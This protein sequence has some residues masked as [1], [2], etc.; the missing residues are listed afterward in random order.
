MTGASVGAASTRDRPRNAGSGE[1]ARY[2]VWGLIT[3]T[4]IE[5]AELTRRHAE[6]DVDGNL[7][8]TA[9]L[10]RTGPPLRETQWRKL[11][12]PELAALERAGTSASEDRE[13]LEALQLGAER[14]V[15]Q[16]VVD[17]RKLDGASAL[18][19]ASWAR[20][21]QILR[22]HFDERI[23]ERLPSFL[24]PSWTRLYRA[25]TNG[26]VDFYRELDHDLRDRGQPSLLFEV[27]FFCF[28]HDFVGRYA[29][30]PHTITKY[31]ADIEDRIAFEVPPPESV[32]GS[33]HRTL[34]KPWPT[35]RYYAAALLSAATVAVLLTWGSWHLTVET[36]IWRDRPSHVGS[37]LDAD[38]SASDAG[39]QLCAGQSGTSQQS[40][41]PSMSTTSRESGEQ[42]EQAAQADRDPPND[43]A[44]GT[45]DGDS[46]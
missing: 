34:R 20:I 22:I 24:R 3:A 25:S 9:K 28:R 13:T 8:T 23:L 36:Y 2:R 12:D 37:Q 38:A 26:G 31:L 7:P 44:E 18:S 15:A 16:L 5:L 32:E 35:W 27:Y 14:R 6:L 33:K 21:E 30:E 41:A 4:S 10:E 17:L 11:D 1:L 19:E 40:S 46:G 42:T 43:G 29:H 39:R 45:G